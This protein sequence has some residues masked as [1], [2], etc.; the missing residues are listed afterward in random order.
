MEK[1]DS[2]MTLVAKRYSDD[3]DYYMSL[4]GNFANYYNN[5]LQQSLAVL[6]RVAQIAK[7]YKRDELSTKIEQDLME[8]L[9]KSNIQ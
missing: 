6:Q 3:I 9:G 7:Q 1:G 5:D 4:E 2:V 8:R